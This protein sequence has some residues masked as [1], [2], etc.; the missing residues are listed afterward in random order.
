MK[1]A[2]LLTL[3]PLLGSAGSLPNPGG[4][5]NSTAWVQEVQQFYPGAIITPVNGG[6]ATPTISVTKVHY[7]PSASGR[8]ATTITPVSLNGGSF[9]MTLN[10]IA[11]GGYDWGSI[12]VDQNILA[13]AADVKV[14]P[15]TRTSFALA[16]FDIP[17]PGYDAPVSYDGSFNGFFGF[18]YDGPPSSGFEL[19]AGGLGAY[20]TSNKSQSYRYS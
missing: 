11:G 7:D 13:F 16:G 9:S 10:G 4:Y 18:L 14:L 5:Y 15:T 1:L 8:I 20:S 2:A 19:N 17:S 6:S 12:D 3:L